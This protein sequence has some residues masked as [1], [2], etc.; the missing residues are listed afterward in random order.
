MVDG[1]GLDATLERMGAF[2]LSLKP[3][4]LMTLDRMQ[5]FI[6]RYVSFAE[7]EASDDVD[8]IMVSV[9]LGKTLLLIDGLQKAAGIE[10]A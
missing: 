8:D 1:Y 3:G 7:V 5:A 9:F 6:D 10:T 2:W 4:T